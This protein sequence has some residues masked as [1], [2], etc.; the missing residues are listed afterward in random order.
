MSGAENEAEQAKKSDW[1]GE[2]ESEKNER[3]GARSVGRG[4]GAE[5]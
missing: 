5:R 2:R 4:A 3:S 1:S